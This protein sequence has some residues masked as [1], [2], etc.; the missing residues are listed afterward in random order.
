MVLIL[1]CNCV[2]KDFEK[3]NHFRKENYFCLLIHIVK[4]YQFMF[5]LL[6]YPMSTLSLAFNSAI[7]SRSRYSLFRSSL[8]ALRMLSFSIMLFLVSSVFFMDERYAEFS[9]LMTIALFF[10]IIELFTAG[11]GDIYLHCSSGDMTDLK[12][13]IC[14]STATLRRLDLLRDC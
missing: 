10:A 2:M 13:A 4:N 3:N 1:S 5:H 6:D 11:V 7:S 8:R 12:K 14:L 9:S